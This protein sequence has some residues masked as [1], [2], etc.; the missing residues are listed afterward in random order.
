MIP[1]SLRAILSSDPE[2]MGGA[3]CFTGTRIP[4]QTLLDNLRAAIPIE[5]ILDAYPDLTRE[6]VLAVINWEDEEA[7]KALGLEIAL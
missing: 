7:R 4:V 5:E 6:H 2:V 3:I 1:N